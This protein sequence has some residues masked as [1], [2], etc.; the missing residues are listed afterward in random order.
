MCVFVYKYYS[1]VDDLQPLRLVKCW[2]L[3]KVADKR[4]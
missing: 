3:V 2:Q 4:D 1:S